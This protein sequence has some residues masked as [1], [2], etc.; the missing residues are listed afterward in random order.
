GDA[1]VPVGFVDFLLHFARVEAQISPAKIRFVFMAVGLAND[2]LD[3]RLAAG[4]DAVLCLAQD[5]GAL[6]RGLYR[7]RRRRL[8]RRGRRTRLRLAVGQRETLGNQEKGERQD[9]CLV[10]WPLDAAHQLESFHYS[11]TSHTY[12]RT[13]A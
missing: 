7:S 1:D 12:E 6:L 8:R 5:A 2:L 3:L 11:I 4:I 10:H 13:P 9:T